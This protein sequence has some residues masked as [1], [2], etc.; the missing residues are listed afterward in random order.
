[1]EAYHKALMTE[2]EL[3]SQ[4]VTLN[5]PLETV[6]LGGGTPSTWPDK[7]LLD[8]FGKLESTFDMSQISEITIETNPG[9]VSQKQLDVWKEAGITRL[10]IGV[11]S[12]NDDVLK[13]LNRHQ[14]ASDVYQLIDWAS[15]RFMSLSIDLIIGLPGV[16]DLEWRKMVERI[17]QWPIDHVSMYFL[18]IH[19]NTPL[20]TRLLKNELALPEQDPIVDL[21]YWTVETFAKYGLEQ[22]EI[23]SFARKGRQAQHNQV[24]WE[25][26][27]YKGFG[28]GA[29]S[30]DGHIRFQN[31][32]NI[33]RYMQALEQ[34][35]SVEAFQER[36][37]SQQI[38]LEK[39]ML[40]LRR[41]K[42]LLIDDVIS[43]MNEDEKKRFLEK[44]AEFKGAKLIRGDS[45]RIYLEK[46]VLAVENE[47]AVRLLQ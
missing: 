2:I 46:S 4:Q 35:E 15:G 19:E 23:S 21:Y 37:T 27:P 22:Y 10:S 12:L 24:Y 14:K 43:D 45:K 18:S 29:C 8:M 7:L 20:Y 5:E 6:Y 33:M 28:I 38:R 13:K 42:G 16:D 36:L 25:R 17:V 40:G 26:K 9:T 31:K 3:F 47:V 34:N 30:F 41:M 11:Q 1:M 39:V 44:I 32:K